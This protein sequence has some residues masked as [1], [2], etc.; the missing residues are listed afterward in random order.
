M[1][2]ATAATAAAGDLVVVAMIR[3][4][5]GVGMFRCILVAELGVEDCDFVCNLRI[6]VA[7]E[8]AAEVTGDECAEVLGLLALDL[9]DPL[10]DADETTTS[11]TDETTT[12][13]DTDDGSS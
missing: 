4:V 7:G 2:A 1:A 9:R 12:G 10:A 11:G 5:G 3:F 13:R 8:D 6:G